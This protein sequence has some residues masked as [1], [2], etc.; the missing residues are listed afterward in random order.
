MEAHVRYATR[1]AAE[2]LGCRQAEALKLLKAAG[3]S[4]TRC[5]SSYLWDASSVDRLLALLR[6]RNRIAIGSPPQ[7]AGHASI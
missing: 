7:G 6:R 1:E 5:G 4:H 2:L 3:A